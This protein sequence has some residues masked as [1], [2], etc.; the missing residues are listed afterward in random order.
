MAKWENFVTPFVFLQRLKKW[1]LEN[2]SQLSQVTSV[3][4]SMGPDDLISL[5]LSFDLP[6]DLDLPRKCTFVR[7]H[8]MKLDPNWLKTLSRGA[9]ALPTV[10][11]NDSLKAVYVRASTFT[12]DDDFLAQLVD[13]I[14]TNLEDEDSFYP[15]VQNLM[16]CFWFPEVKTPDTQT[17]LF[18]AAILAV[19]TGD[20]NKRLLP[21]WIVSLNLCPPLPTESQS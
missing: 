7:G 20:P 16:R 18:F 12:N 17:E 13:W 4:R 5:P 14:D 19:L 15:I 21:F 8:H 3:S 2:P 6:S 10:W 9:A 11:T 1:F